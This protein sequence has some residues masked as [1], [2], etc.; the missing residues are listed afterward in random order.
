MPTPFL[1]QGYQEHGNYYFNYFPKYYKPGICTHLV[2]SYGFG[3]SV[4]WQSHMKDGITSCFE[5]DYITGKI[6]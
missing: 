4:D 3:D 1:N 6:W 5:K 2:V